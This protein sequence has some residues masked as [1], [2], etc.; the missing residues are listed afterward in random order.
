[1]IVFFWFEAWKVCRK[2]RS[3]RQIVVLAHESQGRVEVRFCMQ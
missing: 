3:V 1:M 2:E